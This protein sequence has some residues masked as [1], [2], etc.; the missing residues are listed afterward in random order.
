MNVKRKPLQNAMDGTRVIRMVELYLGKYLVGKQFSP[1]VRLFPNL[2]ESDISTITN[3]DIQSYVFSVRKN[4]EYAAEAYSFNFSDTTGEYSDVL[5]GSIPEARSGVTGECIIGLMLEVEKWVIRH[6]LPLIGHC[7]DSASNSLNALIQL[8]SPATYNCTGKTLDFIGLP[9]SSFRFFA[10]IFR[11]PYP[12]IAYPCW[13][14]PGRTVVRNIMN[15]NITIV[16]GI[17]PNN[18]D[19]M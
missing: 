15:E 4:N 13:D 11:S 19:G 1:D 17:L 8:A 14:H 18:G 2:E 16:S 9:I 12:S 7:T 5:V 3:E 6:D 10:P